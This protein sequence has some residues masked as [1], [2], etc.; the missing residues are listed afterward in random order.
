MF[1]NNRENI[2]ENEAATV[3]QAAFRGYKTRRDIKN[4][5]TA[6]SLGNYADMAWSLFWLLALPLSIAIYAT[7]SLLYI[8]TG[9][10]SALV[11]SARPTA[12]LV[13]LG[14]ELPTWTTR[15]IRLSRTLP[16][17]RERL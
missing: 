6:S 16:I 4:M 9:P 15:N 7:F 3:I 10:L 5:K 8:M 11:P 2:A 12:R 14:L 13:R 17:E 1:M